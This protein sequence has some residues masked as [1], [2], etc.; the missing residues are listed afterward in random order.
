MSFRE[1]CTLATLAILALCIFSY[2]FGLR[3]GI[4][5]CHHGCY[6]CGRPLEV[7]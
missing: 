6:W 5:H 7:K 1:S 3:A 2:L 4:V